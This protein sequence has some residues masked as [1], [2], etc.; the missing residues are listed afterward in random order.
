MI[1][2]ELVCI[3]PLKTD[4]RYHEQWELTP[5]QS[6]SGASWECC[7]GRLL[8]KFGAMTRTCKPHILKLGTDQEQIAGEGGGV[9]GTP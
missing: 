6:L 7:Q 8:S 2:E 3:P 1:S 5:E 4:Y 9:G